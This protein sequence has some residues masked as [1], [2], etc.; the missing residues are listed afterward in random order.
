MVETTGTFSDREIVQ[1]VLGRDEEADN[2]SD[3]NSAEDE[4]LVC[5]SV[6][7]YRAALKVVSQYVACCSDDPKHNQALL[8]LE[9]L[10]FKARS[11]QTSITDYFHSKSV[12]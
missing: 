9:D 6:D 4:P 7:D 3:S 10:S 1:A 8:T 12:Q 11:K 5:P 2:E